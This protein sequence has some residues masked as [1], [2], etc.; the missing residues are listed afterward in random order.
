MFI[1]VT[2]VVDLKTP[3]TVTTKIP[4]QPAQRSG[5][6]AVEPVATSRVASPEVTETSPVQM[7]R[8]L[9]MDIALPLNAG[10]KQAN[11][12]RM[13]EREANRWLGR[14]GSRRRTRSRRSRSRSRERSRSISRPGSRLRKSPSLDMSDDEPEK[15]R[16]YTSYDADESGAEDE[17]RRGRSR[18]VRA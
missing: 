17:A 16:R 14:S 12:E 11:Q 8:S 2:I 1:F 6:L 9:P 13:I 15:E 7:V 10:A 5:A 4:P 18:R 3:P